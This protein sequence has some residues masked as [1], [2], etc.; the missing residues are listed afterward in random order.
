MAAVALLLSAL[1]LGW[2]YIRNIRYVPRPSIIS[3]SL[4]RQKK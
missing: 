1:I 4:D 2:L 3:Q